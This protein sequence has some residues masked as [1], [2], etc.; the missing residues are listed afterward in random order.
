M[1]ARIAVL[2]CSVL[3]LASCSA[4]KNYGAGKI[5]KKNVTACYYA[6]KFNGRKTASGATFSNN[7]LTAAHKKLPFG[8][9]VRVT[10]KSN[11]KSVVVEINDR[12]PFSGGFEIDM[13]RRAYK[14]IADPKSRAVMRV[15]I[16]I[17]K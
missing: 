11:N 6:D 15:D 4:S 14:E 9:K 5:Y 7:G 8:T 13:A 10:N 1:K 12:G 17:V 3:F 2:I 16:E